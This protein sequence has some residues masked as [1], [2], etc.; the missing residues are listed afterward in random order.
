MT[1]NKRK[2]NAIYRACGIAIL[3]LLALLLILMLVADEGFIRE[4]RIV[5]IIEALMLVAFGFSWLVK[6]ETILK[7]QYDRGAAERTRR[8]LLRQ[9][10]WV[11]A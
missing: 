1:G 10:P 5:L 2:R 8:K 6:G 9:R 4:K 7:D 11:R 3:S